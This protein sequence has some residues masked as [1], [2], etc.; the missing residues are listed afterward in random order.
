MQGTFTVAGQRVRTS[1]QR[2]YVI[3]LVCAKASGG[4]SVSIHK[5][6]DSL[7]KARRIVSNYGWASNYRLVIVDTTTGETV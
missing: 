3:F 7:D 2:R 6:T 5:R 4:E 1:S